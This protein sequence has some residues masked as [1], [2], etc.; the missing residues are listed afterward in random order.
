MADAGRDATE[1]EAE[2]LAID[3]G[4]VNRTTQSFNTVN[5]DFGVVNGGDPDLDDDPIAPH[6]KRTLFLACACI[7]GESKVCGVQ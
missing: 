1:Q 3:K 7:L 4:L 2:M 6:R 5:K